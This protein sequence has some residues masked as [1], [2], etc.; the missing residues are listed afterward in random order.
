MFPA[1]KNPLP[2]PPGLVFPGADEG[3][4][5]VL[6]S[7]KQCA[8]GTFADQ[9]SGWVHPQG[10]TL[11][12]PG[13]RTVAWHPLRF[14]SDCPAYA[15]CHT[16]RSVRRCAEKTMTERI[17]QCLASL[18]HKVLKVVRATLHSCRHPGVKR[19]SCRDET[20]CVQPA[21]M[22]GYPAQGRLG[23]LAFC[24]VPCGWDAVAGRS[25]RKFVKSL[26]S[27]LLLL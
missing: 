16:T 19:G 14:F 7:Y 22:P 26:T 5:A 20:Q 25:K 10:Q 6:S 1:G 17:R 2:A 23:K 21:Q 15:G 8:T 3:R 4:G 9:D 27:S 24:P 18:P 11:G 12:C 13:P